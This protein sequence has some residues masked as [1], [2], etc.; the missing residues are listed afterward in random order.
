MYKPFEKKFKTEE[1]CLRF[2]ANLRWPN[3]RFTC[4]A[5]AQP[6]IVKVQKRGLIQCSNCRRQTSITASTIFH[7]AK[8]S[9]LKL[10]RIFW[11]IAHGHNQSAKS[12]SAQLQLSYETCWRWIKKAQAIVSI[13]LNRTV[14]F[15]KELHW[16]HF[17]AVVFRRSRDTQTEKEQVS[18]QENTAIEQRDN[19]LISGITGFIS[20]IF[21][22]VSRKYLQ[23]YADQF[24]LSRHVSEKL[25]SSLIGD[26]LRT[27]PISLGNILEYSSPDMIVL[28]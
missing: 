6:G 3:G 21:H 15:R 12:V 20:E 28:A 5:C 24:S 8:T 18:T 19:I 2:L 9:L 10:F 13:C 26:C 14:Q 27:G 25:F 7:G 23:R 16:S 4:P 17:K 22:G 1:D 11:N